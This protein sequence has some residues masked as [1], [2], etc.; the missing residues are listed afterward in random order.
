M[1]DGVSGTDA[2][3]RQTRALALAGVAARVVNAGLA[4]VTQVL[5]ARIMGAAE[6]GVSATAMTLMLLTAGVATLGLAMMPQRFL[7]EYEAEGDTARLRGL[8]RFS[9][10]APPAV[11]AVFAAIGCLAVHLLG[12]ILSPAVAAAACLAMLAVPAQCS[13]DVVEG[14]A[15]ARGWK[16]LAYGF[17]FVLRPL[18]VPLIFIAAWLGGATADAALASLALAGATIAAA[19]I[20]LVMVLLKSARLLRTGPAIEERGR[21]LRAGLPV[22]LMETAFLLMS[23][24]DIILL[25]IFRDDATVG[26]YGAAARL[27]A[28]VAFIH[29]GLTWA[30]GHHFSALH[31]AGERE[32]L[33]DFAARAAR[34]TFWPSLGLAIAVALAA[35]LLLMLFGKGFEDGGIVTAILLLGLLARAAAGP[36]EQLLVMTD[37][38]DS[39][40]YAYG[41]AFVV[42]VGLGVTL[43]PAHGPI[44]AAVS[45]AIA[46]LAASLIVAREVQGRLGFPVHLATLAIARRRSMAHA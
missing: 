12:S 10:W 27:V 6:Y 18:L 7:P 20:L 28:L 13:L 42:N 22:M 40:A 37:N 4:F 17:A 16:L 41:W 24:T 9:L 33:A 31:A 39:C 38:Q 26:A 30:S 14:I 32:R 34:W 15:L 3:E 46:Y 11:G 43:I 44:G 19:A 21:W 29:A 35:P 2:M 25:A 45:T 8:L 1:Q 36:A 23:S 5:F